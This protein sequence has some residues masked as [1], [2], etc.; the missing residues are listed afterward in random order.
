MLLQFPGL[1]FI[2]LVRIVGVYFEWY[3]ACYFF[4]VRKVKMDM[5]AIQT[6][7]NRLNGA[8]GNSTHSA[9]AAS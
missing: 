4:V 6:S 2:V 1:S 8:L 5:D 3:F 7:V 9:S